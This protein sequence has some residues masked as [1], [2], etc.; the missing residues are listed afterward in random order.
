MMAI[1]GMERTER[2]WRTLLEGVGLAVVS[3]EQ[4]KGGTPGADG[5]IIAIL[6]E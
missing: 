6:R 1:G 5:M 2:Q 3:I 4:P